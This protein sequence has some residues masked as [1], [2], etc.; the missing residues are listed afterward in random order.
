VEV[1]APA[2]QQGPDHLD[3]LS[4]RTRRFATVNPELSK[5]RNPSADAKNSSPARNLVERRDRHRSQ[6]WMAREGIGDAW[7]KENF[8]SVGCEVRQAGVNLAVKPFIS[9]PYRVV[10]DS[11][12]EPRAVDHNLHRGIAKHQQVKSDIVDFQ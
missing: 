6:R 5:S 2:A 10:T 1:H 3:H 8:R 4:D 12:R 11:L 7:A 9:Q